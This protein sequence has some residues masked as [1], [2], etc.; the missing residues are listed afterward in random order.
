MRSYRGAIQLAIKFQYWIENNINMFIYHSTRK[1]SNKYENK[2]A[3]EN[4]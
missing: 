4:N 1:E 2:T 3:L